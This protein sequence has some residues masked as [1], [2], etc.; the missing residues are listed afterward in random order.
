MPADSKW[1]ATAL[2]DLARACAESRPL[3]TLTTRNNLA[4]WRSRG[5][6]ESGTPD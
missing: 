6:G 3:D 4:H 1:P 5:V 2:A